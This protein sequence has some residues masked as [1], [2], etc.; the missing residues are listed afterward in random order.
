M[1][2]IKITP[3]DEA[4]LQEWEA[5]L[6]EANVNYEIIAKEGGGFQIELPPLAAQKIL[7]I[8]TRPKTTTAQ[9]I[10]VVIF[11]V[12]MVVAVVWILSPEEEKVKPDLN[13]LSEEELQ[14][15]YEEE[16]GKEGDW[17]W[18]YAVQVKKQYVTNPNTFLVKDVK[19]IA[20]D[21]DSLTHIM[22]FKADNL[23]G[24]S[25]DHAI[26]SV[27]SSDGMVNRIVNIN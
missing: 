7:N 13:T 21:K 16:F 8:S 20:I 27:I 19:V 3:K 22:Y 17:V 15:Y 25:K 1:S 24:Q 14:A 26:T 4:Q 12:F 5:A 18:N 6:K 10:G 9:W 23:L 11:A 2:T